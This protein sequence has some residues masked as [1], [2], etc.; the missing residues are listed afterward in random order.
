MT[1]INGIEIDDINYIENDIKKAIINNDPI[2]D[3]LHVIIVISNPSNSAV[4]YILTREF[5]KRMKDDVNI[6]L[7]IVELAYGT[8]GYHVTE[9]N[10]K[11]HLRLRTTHFPIWHKE[12]L[13]NIGVQKLLPP[14]WKAFAWLDADIEFDNPHWASD[15]LK[16][17]N[18]CKDIVQ[19]F[20]NTLFMDQNMNT[21]TIFTGL[22]YQY[23]KKMK[24]E[25]TFNN[26]YNSIWHPGFAWACTRKLYEKIGGLYEYVITGGGDSYIAE[27]ILG[28]LNAII[29]KNAVG[30]YRQTLRDFEKNI[31]GCRLG[32]VP[33]IIRHYYHGTIS[34]RK[35]DDRNSILVK[36]KYSPTI[37][38]KKDDN[39]L[40]IPTDLFPEELKNFL[41]NYFLSRNEDA[42][43]TKQII[44]LGEMHDLTK[45]NCYLIN[46]EKDTERLK[47]SM[48]EL[49]KLDI[50]INNVKIINATYWKNKNKFED[51]LNSILT[52]LNKFNKRIN[53][54]EKIMI[55]EFSEINDD[56]IKIQDAPLACYCSHLRAMIDSYSLSN[57]EYTIIAEDDISIDNIAYIEK[58]INLIPKDWDIITFNSIPKIV[59][60]NIFYKFDCLFYHLHF[61]IIKN[62]CFEKIFE[63]IYPITDQVDILIG[64]MHNILNIYNITNTVSQKNF[65][66]NIQNNLHVIYTTPVY[67]NLVYEL[68]SLDTICYLYVSNKLIDNNSKINKTITNKIIDDVVYYNIFNHLDLSQT[69]DTSILKNIDTSLF[70]QLYK[71]VKYFI[72]NKTIDLY[73]E[74]LINM[75]DYILDSFTL[76]NKY[77]EK[78][79]DTYKAHSF[80]CTSSTYLIDNKIIKVYNDKLRW[81]TTNHDDLDKIFKKELEIL[82]KLDYLIDYD[83]ESKILV[84]KYMG[85]TLYNNFELAPNWNNQIVLEFIKLSEN[86][87]YYPEFNLNNIV[88]LNDKISIIDFGLAE[89][90][91]NTD[92]SNNYNVFIKLLNILN[93]KFQTVKETKERHILYNKFMNNIRINKLY[94]SNVF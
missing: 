46:L 81:S 50:L 8:Q 52:F 10:N 6:I 5:I 86:G 73:V 37:H 78:Y 19:L 77:S 80:G 70:R 4:R 18:G 63:N 39:G 53:L 42:H 27:C 83:N 90:V 32:Y 23:V 92:N 64:N 93:E 69:N 47:S 58:Y 2:E 62:K 11:N 89:I 29:E 88:V 67:K 79:K 44:N 20:S 40:L 76:H 17:L 30:E 3:K 56:N 22:A 16:V 82:Q 65:E 75:I 43:L 34:D 66:T 13:I 59:N 49:K 7:Y 15:T 24:R 91:E 36:C 48:N 57:N 31:T 68:N 14:T 26:N 85:E 94:I 38:L 9:R 21:D 74:R 87:I 60:N 84:M 12:N 41:N 45:N 35:Y 28:N 51:D 61:Y 54:L 25:T 71:V 1:I 33:G 55:N 72:K